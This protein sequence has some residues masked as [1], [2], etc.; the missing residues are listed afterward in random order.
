MKDQYFGD[1]GDYQKVSLLKC[2]QK[3]NLKVLVHW[4]KT[5]DDSSTDGKHITYLEK[6]ELWANFDTDVF[7]LLKEKI[8]SGERS[9][10]HI[11]TSEFCSEVEFINEYIEDE[12]IRKKTLEQVIKSNAEVVLFDPD[13]GI[14]VVSSNMKNIHK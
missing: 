2:L 10:T 6:S 8:G 7:K 4:L 12:D 3:K 9:L 13:N 5:K 11:E 14:Q 1:F